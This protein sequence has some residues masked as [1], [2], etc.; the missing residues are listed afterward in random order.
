MLIDM[1]VDAGGA[2]LRTGHPQRTLE[3]LARAQRMAERQKVANYPYLG[4]QMGDALV[5]LGRSEEARPWVEHA[6]APLA[7]KKEPTVEE[8]RARADGHFVLARALIHT[9]PG[10]AYQHAETAARLYGE[11]APLRLGSVTKASHS[12]EAWR[13]SEHP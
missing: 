1:L 2:S 7:E 10:A 6:L 9:A 13:T 12:L 4:I 8:R 5:T 3:L 11:L